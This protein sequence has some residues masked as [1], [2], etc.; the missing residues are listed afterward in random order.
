MSGSPVSNLRAVAVA[1]VPQKT[2][3]AG[4]KVCGSPSLTIFK[5]T[6]RCS[7]CGVL[8]FFPYPPPDTLAPKGDRAFRQK[9]WLKWYCESGSR[10]PRN[11]ANMIRFALRDCRHDR[12]LSI[13]DYGGG[14]GQF[15]FSALSYFP[16][17]TVWI[18]DIDDDGLLPQYSVANRQIPYAR[19]PDDPTRFDIIFLNDVFE[20]VEAPLETLS[21]LATKLNVGGRVLVDTPKTFWL[22]PVLR[23]AAPS[24]YGKL[25]DGTVTRA[26][27][28][29][30]TRR[31]FEHVVRASSLRIARY[32]EVSEFSMPPDFYLESMAVKSAA[33]RL[34]G[35][36][37]YSNARWLAKNK[38]MAVLTTAG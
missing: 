33:M 7:A 20:H 16:K 3:V 30:W 21:L 26:H 14:G 29:I 31:S 32:A 4:C 36:L 12:E 27:L 5:H 15:A 34:A 10:S 35:R 1:A 38:I 8:L 17:A 11:F 13:L 24:L 2:A 18:T 22:Y 9:L 25:C 19:F 6:A 23:A 37:F 28:Q